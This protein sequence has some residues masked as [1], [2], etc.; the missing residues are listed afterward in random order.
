MSRLCGWAALLAASVGALAKAGH[1]PLTTPPLDRGFV[2]WAAATPPQLACFSLMRLAALGVGCYLLAAAVLSL[3]AGITRW[4]P[5]IRAANLLTPPF[6]RVVLTVAV[7]STALSPAMA[8]AVP[9]P[10]STLA[11]GAGDPPPTMV[12]VDP[13]P[14]PRPQPTTWVVQPGDNLWSIATRV[15]T[16]PADVAAYWMRLVAQSRGR[17]RFRDKPD[18]IYPGQT[19]E[20]PAP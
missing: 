6:L 14:T 8:A 9:G 18:L 17:L 1:G 5:I 15:E 19:F 20:L 12:L 10:G 13:A 11:P 16:T 2:H 7:T 4:H 3:V